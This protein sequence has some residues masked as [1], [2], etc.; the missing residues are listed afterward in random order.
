MEKLNNYIEK[1]Q[2]K[3]VEYSKGRQLIDDITIASPKESIKNM[4]KFDPD[5]SVTELYL[6]IPSWISSIT[7]TQK[8]SDLSIISDNARST[9]IQEL[10]ILIQEADRL[11]LQLEAQHE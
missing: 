2:N 1:N 9:V 10:K 6:T 3:F 8:N 11:L 4:P 7:R 5:A